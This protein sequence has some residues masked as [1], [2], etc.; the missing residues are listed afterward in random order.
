M[1]EIGGGRGWENAIQAFFLVRPKSQAVSTEKVILR[2]WVV[3]APL[4][5]SQ[6]AWAMMGSGARDGGLIGAVAK[7]MW[8]AGYPISLLPPPI[9]HCHC[10]SCFLVSRFKRCTKHLNRPRAYMYIVPSLWNPVTAC[11]CPICVCVRAPYRFAWQSVK[12]ERSS[13]ELQ[14]LMAIG[15]GLNLLPRPAFTH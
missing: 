8:G 7:R 1:P 3:T 11:T 10:G 5:R 12:Q 15:R 2:S 4:S 14:H 9:P 13:R 6:S